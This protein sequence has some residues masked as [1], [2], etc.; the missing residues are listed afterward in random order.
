MP[1]TKTK[2]IP[3]NDNQGIYD[4]EFERMRASGVMGKDP[5]TKSLTPKEL[6][7]AENEVQDQIGEGYHEESGGRLRSSLPALGRPKKKAK[8]KKKLL[9]IG[10]GVGLGFLALLIL[11]IMFLSSFKA[12]HFS[13]VLRSVGFARFNLYMKKQ[14]ARTTFNAAVLTDESSG[15]FKLKD[16]GLLDKLS[17][18]N[19]EKQL[20]KLGREGTLKFEFEGGRKWGG[21]RSTNTFKGI[22]INGERINLD[23]IARKF[24]YE[25]YNKIGIAD[26]RGKLGVRAE[27]VNRVRSGLAEPLSLEGRAFRSSVYDGLRQAAGIRMYK[28]LNKGREYLGKNPDEARIKNLEDGKAQ[29][30]E[31]GRAKPRSNIDDVNEGADELAEEAENALKEGRQPRKISPKVTRLNGFAQNLST[32]VFAATTA[33]IIHDLNESFKEVTPAREKQAAAFGHSIHT[34]A[35]QIKSGDVAAEAVGAENERWEG[36]EQAAFYKQAAGYPISTEDEKQVATAPSVLPP[37]SKFAN[38]LDDVDT[39]MKTAVGGPFIAILGNVPGLGDLLKKGQDKLIDVGCQTVLNPFVQGTIAAGEVGIAIFTAGTAEGVLQ[40]IKVGLQA[41]LKFAGTVGVG[42]LLGSLIESA[43]QSYS[44]TDFSATSSGTNLYN[45]GSVTTDYLQQTGTRKITYGR[46]MD[47]AET[48]ASQEV[49]ISDLKATQNKRGFAGRY[50]AADNPFSL[51]GRLAAIVP[52]N[53]SGWL[54][55]IKHFGASLIN[56]LV[57]LPGVLASIFIPQQ[58]VAAASGSGDYSSFG[59]NGWGWT[60]EE[61]ARLD[62]DEAFAPE[63]LAEYVEPRLDELND[64]YGPCYSYVMQHEKPGDCDSKLKPGSA[65]YEEALRWRAYMAESYAAEELAKDLEVN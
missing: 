10:G 13:T 22:E 53:S 6:E 63:N 51:V 3:E 30:G 43:M 50:F 44:G 64:K 14:F 34:T 26:I 9:F 41:G 56:S 38:I 15:K 4:Q 57:R 60:N 5:E 19:P 16:R 29:T 17:R 33:C 25:S 45:S 31:E 12:V 11:L 58:K 65:T 62:S 8:S 20:A 42:E 54:G 27:F 61:Q 46:P 32:G 18:V 39:V 48:I 52:T 2:K 55:S 36:A 59:V 37:A 47:P 49:A 40:A 24:G 35:D 1:D 7:T 21:L 23:D 28:W